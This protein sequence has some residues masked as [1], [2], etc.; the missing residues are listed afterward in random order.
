MKRCVAMLLVASLLVLSG[1]KAL[2]A[3]D[4]AFAVAMGISENGGS[5]EVCARIPAYQTSGGYLTISAMGDSLGE[6]MALLNASAPMELHYGQL[7]LLL[8]SD[9]LAA[10]DQFAELVRSLTERGEIRPQVSLS[11]T[12]DRVF[13]VVDALEPATGSRLSK[14][15]EILVEARESSGVIQ[16]ATLSTWQRMGE[17][18]QP[19]LINTALESDVTGAIKGMDGTAGEHSA[20]GTGKVQLSGGWIIDQKGRAKGQLSAAE[21]QLLA[22]MRDELWQGTI[23]LPE[24]T[25]TLMDADSNISLKDDE[26]LCKLWVRYS[27]S[28]MTEEGV[29]SALLDSLRSLAG[30]LAADHCDALG[31]GRKAMMGCTTMAE[32]REMDW[33][34]RYPALKWRFVVEVER[35]A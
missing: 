17:R 32:W 10:S 13:D 1:C 12:K 8:F 7:R 34:S 33:P 4:R 11:I 28:G 18:Q 21:M 31:I 6:A 22:L 19:V 3:E 9:T 29:Q 35:E 27:S 14:S 15:L 26:V 25:L 23:S 24:G 2:P 20:K 30:K 16:N 5:W